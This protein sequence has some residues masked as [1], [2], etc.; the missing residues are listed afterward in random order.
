VIEAVVFDL[1]GVL[2]DSEHVWD[3]VREGLAQERGG[4]WTVH[5]Q[6]DMTGMSST[7]GPRHVYP[8]ASSPTGAAVRS[9][10]A[11]SGFGA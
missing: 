11:E 10:L 8:P 9:K 5:A 1:D 7:E 2:V 6:A 3:D 4:R